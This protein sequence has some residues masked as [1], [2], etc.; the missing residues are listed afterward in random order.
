MV[1]VAVVVVAVVAVV[2]PVVMNG[3]GDGDGDGDTQLFPL[4]SQTPHESNHAQNKLIDVVICKA[5][6][7][8]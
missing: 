5:V 7:L 3:G 1:V 6:K 8:C 4:P 2:V